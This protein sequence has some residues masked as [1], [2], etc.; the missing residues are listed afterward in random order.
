MITNWPDEHKIGHRRKKRSISV[1][2]KAV[3]RI[4]PILPQ[5]P[6]AVKVWKF[7]WGLKDD[8][9]FH[10][11]GRVTFISGRGAVKLGQAHFSAIYSFCK[12]ESEIKSELV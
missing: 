1:K 6:S 9:K 7:V 12:S 8:Y 10:I 3:A 2:V 5:K 4:I 11:T